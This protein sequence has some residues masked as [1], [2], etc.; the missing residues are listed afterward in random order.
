MH[1]HPLRIHF[2]STHE[3]V[4]APDA[5]P[6]IIPRN[7]LPDEKGL[8]RRIGVFLGGTANDRFAL[9]RIE[10]L[11]PFSLADGIDR[12]NDEALLDQVEQ[13]HLV[14]RQTVNPVAMPAA[15]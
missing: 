3:I 2:A 4:D 12:E 15:E 9:A 13:G 10:I 8:R 14:G 5:I 6:S 11:Q 1:A 7:R